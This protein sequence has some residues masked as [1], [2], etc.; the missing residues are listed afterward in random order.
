MRV[1][2]RRAAGGGWFARNLDTGEDTRHYVRKSRRGAIGHARRLW[3]KI[4]IVE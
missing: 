3:G 1:R 2:I 4:I